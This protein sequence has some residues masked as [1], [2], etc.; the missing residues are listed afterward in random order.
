[1]RCQRVATT[2]GRPAPTT[3]RGPTHGPTSA[4]RVDRTLIDGARRRR[5]PSQSPMAATRERGSPGEAGLAR[6]V[7]AALFRRPRVRLGLTLGPTAVWMVI[8]YLT[9]LALMLVTAFW[10]LNELSSK[11]ERIWGFQN[12]QT[13]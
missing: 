6:R 9:S 12:F 7:S 10:R 11:I 13:L 8:V 4:V 2:A 1:R 5:A 3:R